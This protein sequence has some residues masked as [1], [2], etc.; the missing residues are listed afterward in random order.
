MPLADAHFLLHRDMFGG[1]SWVER[2][3]FQHVHKSVDYLEEPGHDF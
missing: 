2:E 3:H 1:C